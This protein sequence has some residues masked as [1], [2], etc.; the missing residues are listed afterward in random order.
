MSEGAL[1]AASRGANQ[2]LFADPSLTS[3]TCPRRG[4]A[5]PVPDL[6][7]RLVAVL[8]AVLAAPSIITI[9]VLDRPALVC[10]TIQ[11]IR[12]SQ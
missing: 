7:A 10:A 4:A 11:T 1:R 3:R 2:P 8:V 12:P 9:P 6:E 5:V